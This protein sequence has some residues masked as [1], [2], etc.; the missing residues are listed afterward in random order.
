MLDDFIL[1]ALERVLFER[2]KICASYSGLPVVPRLQGAS[3]LEL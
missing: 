2:F 1:D 3:Y